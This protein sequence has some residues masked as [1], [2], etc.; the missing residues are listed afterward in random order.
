MTITCCANWQYFLC[1]T[2]LDSR[3]YTK[4]YNTLPWDFPSGAVDRKSSCEGR[5]HGFDPWS[6]KIPPASVQVSMHAAT[7]EAPSFCSKTRE[8]TA[9]RSSLPQQKVAPA[10]HNYRESPHTV[11]KDLAQS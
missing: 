5:G 4:L 10:H 3:N 1:F 8:A 7:T 9:M 11:T 6:G 2:T